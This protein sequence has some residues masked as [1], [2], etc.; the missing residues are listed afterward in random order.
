MESTKPWRVG[1]YAE[2][3]TME[4]RKLCRVGRIGHVSDEVFSKA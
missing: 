3:E 1:N 2:Y 4:G